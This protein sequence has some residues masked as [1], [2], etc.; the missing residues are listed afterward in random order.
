MQYTLHFNA[1]RGQQWTK[2]LKFA[3]HQPTNTVRC[4]MPPPP[5]WILGICGQPRPQSLQ[6]RVQTKKNAI[7]LCPRVR[8]RTDFHTRKFEYSSATGCLCGPVSADG[9]IFFFLYTFASR[10]K[11]QHNIPSLPTETDQLATKAVVFAVGS[12]TLTERCWVEKN[13]G[14]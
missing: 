4:H 7:H 1:G 13:C 2:P 9:N 6:R 14:L 5:L 11:R 12:F 3:L 10:Q 8:E